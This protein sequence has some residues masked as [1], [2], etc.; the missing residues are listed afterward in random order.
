LLKIKNPTLGP[1]RLRLHSNVHVDVNPDIGGVVDRDLEAAATVT[2]TTCFENV[3]IDS[4]TLQRERVY[5]LPQSPPQTT[6]DVGDDNDDDKSNN[7]NENGTEMITLEPAEDSFLGI[8]K[9]STST[10]IIDNWGKKEEKSQEDDS[11]SI[12]Q[13][14]REGDTWEVL[15]V[16]NDVAWIQYITSRSPRTTKGDGFKYMTVPM[17]LEIEVSEDSWESSLIQRSKDIEDGE[18]DFVRFTIYPVWKK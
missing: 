4:M 11:S 2:A 6:D 8:G 3:V 10:P 16:D 1:I 14:T 17:V 18:N 5:V 15:H 7:N 9:A 13:W 12:P